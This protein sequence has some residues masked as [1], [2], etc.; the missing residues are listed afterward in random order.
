[1]GTDRY[2]N[3]TILERHVRKAEKVQAKKKP[4]WTSIGTADAN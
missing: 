1:M 2:P 3:D 4:P